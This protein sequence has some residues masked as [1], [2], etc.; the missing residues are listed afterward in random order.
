MEP[1]SPSSLYHQQH[2]QQQVS[3]HGYS[4]VQQSSHQTQHHHPFSPNSSSPQSTNSSQ[5]QT[6]IGDSPV[7]IGDTIALF[8]AQGKFQGFLTTLDSVDERA[9]VTCDGNLTE[10]PSKMRDYLYRICIAGKHEAQQDYQEARLRDSSN[11]NKL[12][13]LKAFA[14]EEK[15]LNEAENRA[16]RG[17]ILHYGDVIQLLNIKNNKYVTAFTKIPAQLDPSAWRV[18]L[19]RDGNDNSHFRVTDCLKFRGNG[20]QVTYGDEIFLVSVSAGQRLHASNREHTDHKGCFEVNIHNALTSWKI[21][22]YLDYRENLEGYLKAGDVFRLFHSESARYLTLDD[23]EETGNNGKKVVSQKVFLRY[24][25]RTEATSATSS[26]ALWEVEIRQ[27]EVPRGGLAHWDSTIRFKHLST[28]KYLGLA[29][30]PTA[31]PDSNQWYLVPS[32]TYDDKIEF[33]LHPTREVNIGDCVP[34]KSFVR[35][36]NQPT[37][38]WLHHTNDFFDENQKKEKE[39]V[40]LY[41]SKVIAK[42]KNGNKEVFQIIP[43]SFSEVRDLDFVNDAHRFLKTAVEKLKDHSLS[44]A[45]RK[46]LKSLLF[47]LMFFII[48]QPKDE[49]KPQPPSTSS[50][51]PDRDRQKLVREQKLLQIIFELLAAPFVKKDSIPD[52]PEYN[53]YLVEILRYAYRILQLSQKDYRKNQVEI[54]KKFS[55]IIGQVE[56]KQTEESALETITVLIQGNTQFMEGFVGENEIKLFISLLKTPKETKKESKSNI[57]DLLKNLC[58]CDGE[59]VKTQES[60]CKCLLFENQDALIHTKMEN[61][62]VYLYPDSSRP[63]SKIS[64]KQLV[65]DARRSN[66]GESNAEQMLKYYCNQLDLF[67]AMC[68]KRQYDAIGYLKDTEKLSIELI[69]QC[70]VDEDLPIELRAV[71]CR[72]MLH[73]H[74]DCKPNVM[75]QPIEYARVWADIPTPEEFDSYDIVEAKLKVGADGARKE[76]QN[77]LANTINFVENYLKMV[78][79]GNKDYINNL[80]LE[81]MKLVRNLMLFG[82]FNFKKLINLNKTILDILKKSEKLDE[83]DEKNESIPKG[84]RVVVEK[85]MAEHKQ[86]QSISKPPLGSLGLGPSMDIRLNIIEILNF[87]YDIRLDYRITYILVHFK[88]QSQNLSTP[89]K[90]SSEDVEAIFEDSKTNLDG[91]MGFISVKILLSFIINSMA[92]S[93][94]SGAMKLLIRE[95]KQ[96]KEFLNALRQVQLL[97]KKE[98]VQIYEYFRK[99]LEILKEYVEESETW[100]YTK[101]KRDDEDKIKSGLRDEDRDLP[102]PPSGIPNYPLLIGSSK[103]N[104]L[105]QIDIK[106]EQIK[107]YNR[108]DIILRTLS[109]CC[110]DR[111]TNK[112]KKL[113]QSLLQSRGLVKILVDLLSINYDENDHHIKKIFERTHELLQ[114]FCF[115]NPTNQEELYE[116]YERFLKPEKLEMQ[117]LMSIF[118]NNEKLCNEINEEAIRK[119]V[120]FIISQGKKTYFLDFLLTIVKS[121]GKALP[122]VQAKILNELKF[123]KEDIFDWDGGEKIRELMRSMMSTKADKEGELWFHIKLIDLLAACTE[124]K[125]KNNEKDC[126]GLCPFDYIAHIIEDNNCTPRVKEAYCRLLTN[127]YIETEI[128]QEEISRSSKMSKLI[129]NLIDD[130]RKT[131]TEVTEP[132][133]TLDHEWT[134]YF[135]R[136]FLYMIRAFITSSNAASSAETIKNLGELVNQRFVVP[137]N[138]EQKLK[139]EIR[140]TMEIL[141]KLGDRSASLNVDVAKFASAWQKKLARETSHSES[142]QQRANLSKEPPKVQI[143]SAPNDKT[144]QSISTNDET[145]TPPTPPARKRPPRL[146]LNGTESTSSSS[147]D[148]PLLSQQHYQQQQETSD[149]FNLP[150]SSSLKDDIVQSNWKNLI[151]EQ[152]TE[153]EPKIKAELSVLIDVFYQPAALFPIDTQMHHKLFSGLFIS[154]LIQHIL[155]LVMY[156]TKEQIKTDEKVII[157][158]LQ[159]LTELVIDDKTNQAESLRLQLKERYFGPAN[160]NSTTNSN[161]DNKP[162]PTSSSSLPSQNSRSSK[163]LRFIQNELNALGAPKIVVEI[164]MR[165]PNENIFIYAIKF[166][167][168]LL[169]DGNENIQKSFYKEIQNGS[170]KFIKNFYDRMVIAQK[171]YKTGF[172]SQLFAK[173]P[174]TPSKTLLE[175]DATPVTEFP[176]PPPLPSVSPSPRAVA[177]ILNSGKVTEDKE[178]QLNSAIAAT[179]SGYKVLSNK[180]LGTFVEPS[181]QDE[182][183]LNL[184][185]E[186][187]GSGSITPN[188]FAAMI[189]HQLAPCKKSKLPP[190]VTIMEEILEFLRLL[191]ENHYREM[192][193]LLRNDKKKD[194]NLVAETFKFLIKLCGSHKTKT[195]DG[196][197]LNEENVGLFNQTVKTLIEYCQGPCHENQNCIAKCESNGIEFIIELIKNRAELDSKYMEDVRSLK[198]NASKLLLAIIESRSDIDFAEIVAKIV[199]ANLIHHSCEIY[200]KYKKY[201]E[202]EAHRGNPSALKDGEESEEVKEIEVGH[203]IYILCHQCQRYSVELNEQINHEQQQEDC[204]DAIAFFQ[205]KTAQVEVVRRDSPE[206]RVEFIVFAVP[207]QCHFLT[208]ETKKKV[209]HRTE[210]DEKAR[211][212]VPD[213][214]RQV[215]NLQAEMEWQRDLQSTKRLSHAISRYMSKWGSLSFQLAVLLNIIVICYYP[216]GET[217]I[218]LDYRSY[219]ACLVVGLWLYLFGTHKRSLDLV[220]DGT[221][222]LT[223]VL[224]TWLLIHTTGPQSVIYIC[225]ILDIIITVVYLFSFIINRGYR[226]G[227][228][229]ILMDYEMIYHCVYLAFCTLGLFHPLFYSALLLH[230]IYQEETL[231]NVIRS[232]TRNSKSLLLTCLL[233]LI[234]IHIA[235][236]FGYLYFNLDFRRE[237][238]PQDTV[239]DTSATEYSCKTLFQCL[240][241]TINY[242]LRSGGGIGDVLRSASSEESLY[243]GRVIYELFFY[244]F[245]NVIV[246]NL[247][248][249]IIIDTFADLRQ[250]K[251]K[252]EDILRNTCFICGLPRA[253]F[254][255]RA[256]VSFESHIAREHHMWHYLYFMIL[257]RT[258]PKTE[259][260]GPET[261]VYKLMEKN[262]WTWFPIRKAMSLEGSDS[263]MQLEF[264]RAPERFAYSRELDSQGLPNSRDPMTLLTP[265]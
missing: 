202:T 9:A 95:F 221:F 73:L 72:L 69:H 126:A 52:D 205:K 229:M 97:I 233:A 59:S 25:A 185:T 232:V 109:Y 250:E 195:I 19:D 44:A 180:P 27:G 197:Y 243:Y 111:S 81:V 14:T 251:Q 120:N 165:N 46:V 183:F 211:S 34:H 70:M 234:L 173:S 263:E 128:H 40:V 208:E 48:N 29:P 11:E 140:E 89:L 227:W 247:F 216:F 16:Q 132:K 131:L 88:D 162:Y 85:K 209:L 45:E 153:L 114:D 4:H 21:L 74:V 30:D 15:R 75:I 139:K 116:H 86:A 163:D 198:I 156:G 151:D 39:Q 193:D 187:H 3:Y 228:R 66:H 130:I 105:L 32:S 119:C 113:E 6:T 31:E 134:S 190:E 171:A 161:Q 64:L 7:R 259:F 172:K 47:D 169:N 67:C 177:N 50:V 138:I 43:V 125:N 170:E 51:I 42:Q 219:L 56:H 115:N 94:V 103:S 261:Y 90:I 206:Q 26:K 203:N 238:V 142:D 212:K 76:T 118:V 37:R 264:F 230:V 179:E 204:R 224:T 53:R 223:V 107:R 147:N 174:S 222:R 41:M 117:T 252:K 1:T 155:A 82:F 61:N 98:D 133:S 246:L 184:R 160:N 214:F 65:S 176:M 256:G 12:N 149:Q 154:H 57:L 124:G 240:I 122:N 58:V 102:S 245:I 215:D 166:G 178:N 80:T 91:S 237:Y 33:R 136:G 143:S 112:A 255:N 175:R 210:M 249:G 258:K 28:G 200:Q 8:V 189:S 265:C 207:E 84:L 49:S 181:F 152:R 254:D 262:D 218:E 5:I 235:A 93:L 150:L 20:E 77:A 63:E 186:S 225:G 248:F 158:T 148:L 106:D 104:S 253:D 35:I 22:L 62:E 220:F 87:I 146:Q 144:N 226:R 257:L 196:N 123:H 194:Q 36:H 55:F 168:A 260:T 129:G 244:F 201:M 78:G 127:S 164:I 135:S 23:L 110:R 188:T 18:S 99:A 96:R 167:K 239:E 10:T 13:K 241:T 137:E 236:V 199:S 17:E 71:F 2:Y 242:G 217:P 145:K 79:Q 213:F 231:R 38:T 108:V 60:F 54:S 157:Q 159:I 100:V 121:E 101:S 191:C 92:Y 68:F 141:S 182:D 83:P 24:T 192:Q